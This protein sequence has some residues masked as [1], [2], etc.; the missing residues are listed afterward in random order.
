MKIEM[1]ASSNT[2]GLF[3]SL[4]TRS[5][6][7]TRTYLC[8]CVAP[9]QFNT[10]VHSAYV[11]LSRWKHIIYRVLS[12][13]AGL[14]SLIIL[15]SELV[16]STSLHSPIGMLIGAYSGSDSATTQSNST[17]TNGISAYVQFVC[18]ITLAYMS[19]CTYWSLFRLNLGWAYT[20]QGPQQSS[21]SSLIYNGEYFSR[22]QFP[23]GYNFLMTLNAS[24]L[25]STSFSGIMSNIQLVP[26]FG[27]SFTVF[28]PMLM[29]LFAIFTSL[30]LLP[31]MLSWIGVETE[32]PVGGP[33]FPCLDW[34]SPTPPL[35]GDDLLKYESGRLIVINE[36]KQASLLKM[37]ASGGNATGSVGGGI[38]MSRGGLT[39]PLSSSRSS[40]IDNPHTPYTRTD[41]SSYS[42]GSL[43]VSSN[44]YLLDDDEPNRIDD[45]FNDYER[46]GTSSG[47][48][49]QVGRGLHEQNV[50]TSRGKFGDRISGPEA[51]LDSS[52][53]Q[54]SSTFFGFNFSSYFKV[55]VT[56]DNNEEV[57]VKRTSTSSDSQS[58]YSSVPAAGNS[59]PAQVNHG[60]SNGRSNNAF[61]L[62]N[63]MNQ[64][65][66]EDLGGRYS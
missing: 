10:A 33:M 41:S 64:D 58:I 42:R 38:N 5:L 20:L 46:G 50:S 65:D 36:L 52:S 30:N 25:K 35:S 57:A 29:I 55:S 31:R 27:T 56:E 22:L 3:T 12:V 62:S 28:V 8:C 19:L 1:S 53:S 26:L 54:S 32:D 18:F 45:D 9:R 2:G 14:L 59:R 66:D 21:P 47:T 6:Q 24:I 37:I 39:A 61:A 15:W 11:L 43:S 13:L 44:S 40:H 16:L 51:L 7:L 34:F 49:L 63:A 48:T 4:V 60:F 23:L 17:T